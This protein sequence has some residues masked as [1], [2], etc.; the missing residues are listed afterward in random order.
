LIE[1]P[2]PELW[3][4]AQK[5]LA[6]DE[7]ST[8]W[9]TLK[10]ALRRS[11]R[12]LE[13]HDVPGRE[14][15]KIW[16]KH[17]AEYFAENGL[18]YQSDPTSAQTFTRVFALEEIRRFEAIAL[19]SWQKRSNLPDGNGVLDDRNQSA[20]L[21]FILNFAPLM[22]IANANQL[23]GT[24]FLARFV[25]DMMVRFRHVEIDT[26]YG[27]EEAR[28]QF[29]QQVALHRASLPGNFLP[30]FIL[31]VEGATEAILLPRFAALL[32]F[33]FA[34]AGA[35]VVAAGGA[36]QVA[37]RYLYL[38][39]VLKLPIFVVLDRDAEAQNE[40][41]QGSVRTDDH[42]HLLADGEFEDVLTNEAFLPLLNQ[43][44]QS[45]TLSDTIAIPDEEFT[46]VSTRKRTLERLWRVHDMG[47]FDKVGF[48]K[49]VAGELTPSNSEGKGLSPDGVALI[50]SICSPSQWNQRFYNGG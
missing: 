41:L 38:K 39:E 1:P 15:F 29:R 30:N 4:L 3:P 9:V 22:A 40:I 35:M 42:I 18:S 16:Q 24:D 47:K 23:S 43:Y 45:V 46:T 36:N 8:K 26:A 12:R 31:L 17:L 20:W 28:S 33:N 13:L 25:K 10:K 5:T 11:D 34:R 32:G 37:K 27:L 14:Q 6:F 19:L 48:A 49:F 44:I 7:P 21:N 50:K 2:S